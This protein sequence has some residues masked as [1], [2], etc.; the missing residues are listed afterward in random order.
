MF[1]PQTNSDSWEKYE[2]EKKTLGNW[3]N[4]DELSTNHDEKTAS[5]ELKK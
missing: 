1:Y 2:I 3:E 5:D 4:F